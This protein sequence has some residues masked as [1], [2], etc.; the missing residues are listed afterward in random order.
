[1]Q[2]IVFP[3][4]SPIALS[5]GS[6]DIYWY[7]IA[8]VASI[9]LGW[10]YARYLVRKKDVGVNAKKLDDFII[11]ATIGVIVGGR[12]G[13][14]VFYHPL[15]YLAHP[16]E[17]LYFWH[18]GRSFHGGLLGVIFAGGWFCWRRGVPFLALGDIVCSVVPIGLFFGRIANFINAELYG[19]VT[20]VPW[21]VIFPYAGSLPRHPS[22]LY[23]AALEGILLFL[24]LFILERKT[25]IRYARPGL[26]TALFLI[27]YGLTRVVAE[28]YR[29][30]DDHIGFLVGGTTMGQLLSTP[31]LLIGLLLS[32]HVL[33]QKSKKLSQI[34]N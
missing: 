14:V 34:S 17:I 12:L 4:I 32:W 10:W 27:G 1:M 21:G 8:Y 2:G 9:I 29:Q 15:E 28:V 11:W 20:D 26:M 13:H 19:R 24:A 25:K 22:Q 23:E 5:L 31:I 30:P 7:G 6:L 18:P 33:N 16:W 3:D